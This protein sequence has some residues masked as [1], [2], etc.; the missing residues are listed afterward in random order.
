METWSNCKDIAIFVL[1]HHKL[2]N[3]NV[4]AD[5]MTWLNGL[6]YRKLTKNTLAFMS[7]LLSNLQ[8]A[9]ASK[10]LGKK[11]HYFTISLW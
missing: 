10:K 8:Q 5:H 11:F 3:T 1:N 2:G 7:C 6:N 4:M 9:D